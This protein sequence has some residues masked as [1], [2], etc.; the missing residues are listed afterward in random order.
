MSFT[1]IAVDD[2]PLALD[3]IRNYIA[4]IPELRLLQTF[5]DAMSAGEYLRSQD[6]AILFADI[7][8]PGFSGIE[9]VRSLNRKPLII[10]TTAHKGFAHEGFELEAIDYLLKPISFDRFEKAV[11]KAISYKE[12]L[13][14]PLPTTEEEYLFVYAEYSMQKIRLSDI[15]YIE[16]MEDYI[17]IHLA[18]A[19]PV[20]TLMTLK[21]VLEK[22]PASFRRIHRSYIVAVPKVTSILNR[23]A[24]LL[25]GTELPISESHLDFITEWKNNL[26]I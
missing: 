23:K 24:K 12:Y 7:D 9:L 18:D 10:F 20:M 26:K 3:I 15:V 11:R 2:E 22:L 13:D 14:R 5:E 4:R 6:V 8:M 19:K 1:C 16:S 21:A 25:D 17:R